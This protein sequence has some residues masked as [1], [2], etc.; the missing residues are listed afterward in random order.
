MGGQEQNIF[1]ILFILVL[2]FVI[3][4][5]YDG[6]KNRKKLEEPVQAFPQR[7]RIM[8]AISSGALFALGVFYMIVDFNFMAVIYVA[9]G[10]AFIYLTYE[11]ILIGSNGIYYNGK[12]TY[13]TDVKQWGFGEDKKFLHM[14]II[15]KGKKAARMIP[16]RPDDHETINT[17]I[18][19]HKKRKK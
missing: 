16:I 6:F 18:R 14:Q 10:V 2:L 13:W 8:M 4:Q 9:L 15:D 1:E 5:M 3:K 11:K 17:L 12:L 7:I 19:E